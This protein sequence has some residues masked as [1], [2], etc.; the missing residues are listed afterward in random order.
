MQKSTAAAATSLFNDVV[1]PI[2]VPSIPEVSISLQQIGTSTSHQIDPS[3]ATASAD[4]LSLTS[5]FEKAN[6]AFDLTLTT[7]YSV[8]LSTLF[9]RFQE[10]QN[11]TQYIHQL[12]HCLTS[13]SICLVRADEHIKCI[14]A[15]LNSL[16]IESSSCSWTGKRITNMAVLSLLNHLVYI[17]ECFSSE[18]ASKVKL[19]TNMDSLAMEEMMVSALFLAIKFVETCLH[20]SRIRD[21]FIFIDNKVSLMN[22]PSHS[23]SVSSYR[24]HTADPS[25]TSSSSDCGDVHEKP[26]D[27]KA[28]IDT[29]DAVSVH[30]Q[31]HKK[32]RT[33]GSAVT[34]QDR[35]SL[36]LR[37]SAVSIPP[38]AAA[39]VAI[40]LYTNKQ[41]NNKSN[42]STSSMLPYMRRPHTASPR[43]V[44]VTALA[45]AP[46]ATTTATDSNTRVNGAIDSV[47]TSS[48][49]SRVSFGAADGGS[50]KSDDR[51]SQLFENI[52]ASLATDLYPYPEAVPAT[53]IATDIHFSHP[54][55]LPL[56]LHAGPSP[57]V[58]SVLFMQRLL[59]ALRAALTQTTHALCEF[60]RTE[61]SDAVRLVTATTVNIVSGV[62]TTVLDMHSQAVASNGDTSGANERF[63]PYFQLFFRNSASS[64][65]VLGN[66]EQQQQQQQ[67]RES[68]SL[69]CDR[70]L[71]SSSSSLSLSL[72]AGRAAAVTETDNIANSS[73]SLTSSTRKSIFYNSFD[74]GVL[75]AN[76]IRFTSDSLLLQLVVDMSGDS[77]DASYSH[78]AT[79]LG[80][81]NS[82]LVDSHS[83]AV[84]P[85]S[86]GT[87]FSVAFAEGVTNS[88]FDMLVAAHSIRVSTTSGSGDSTDMRYT[89]FS[90][91]LSH[92]LCQHSLPLDELH[93]SMDTCATAARILAVRRFQLQVSSCSCSCLCG[94]LCLRSVCK[95]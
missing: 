41:C 44:A 23:L 52:A 66:M 2:P 61:S 26:S 11:V 8:N 49:M 85:P 51:W 6:S 22:T 86:A 15:E 42:F 43:A 35:G 36:T 37:R 58:G 29:V 54:L 77:S 34:L 83:A 89:T 63:C 25:L 39:A 1:P 80:H 95:V 40:P 73:P 93:R 16:L 92:F 48:L 27:T 13:H 91:I 47:K 46:T 65:S 9:A 78:R 30:P 67:G 3:S 81:L 21:L 55:L 79:L 94:F 7:N 24:T 82:L 28:D 38:A 74:S 87:A 69:M 59:T 71:V 4:S 90:H 33:E 19:E 64:L 45:V 31:A 10:L 88:A 56:G 17:I 5:Y 72:T 14:S 62:L 50:G 20:C 18:M 76:N 53:G 70:T 32:F 75:R 68:K 12:E 57:A 84:T 60:S